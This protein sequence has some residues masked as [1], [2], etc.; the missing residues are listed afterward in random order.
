LPEWP[1]KTE[2]FAGP[3]VGREEMASQHL[4][5][6]NAHRAVEAVATWAV[7]AD[8]ATAA[9]LARVLAAA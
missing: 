2:I 1:A 4:R 6:S 9:A 5:R 3:A 8:P 7:R